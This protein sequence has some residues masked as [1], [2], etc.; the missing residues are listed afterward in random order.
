MADDL[1][2]WRSEFPIL[3]TSTYLVSHSMGAMPRAALDW[4][5]EYAEGVAARRNCGMGALVAVFRGNSRPCRTILA[6]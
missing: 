1:L 6:C 4:L 5:R 3:E 2:S